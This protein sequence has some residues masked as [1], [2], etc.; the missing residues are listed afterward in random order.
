MAKAHV[1]PEQL[2]RFARTLTRFNQGLTEMLQGLRGQMRRL[3]NDWQDQE[4]QKFS[5]SFEQISR[6]LAR[7]LEQSDEHARVLTRKARHIEEYLKQR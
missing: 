6:S 2:Q 7:F 5:E 4:Q 3:E 1:D